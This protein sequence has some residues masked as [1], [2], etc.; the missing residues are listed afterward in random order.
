MK[1]EAGMDVDIDLY[2]IY[3]RGFLKFGAD[4]ISEFRQNASNYFELTLWIHGGIKGG[5][6]AFGAKWN[7]INIYADAVGT[8]A[9][10][11]QTNPN[12]S[13]LHANA[14]IKIGYHLNVLIG[15]VSGS[16]EFHFKHD[17]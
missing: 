17:F 7:I 6:N 16:K 8:L 1:V 10:G 2:I 3:A 5:I 15:S 4:G 9:K 14:D 11:S 12:D 13:K